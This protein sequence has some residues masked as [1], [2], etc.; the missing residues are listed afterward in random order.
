M[1]KIFIL[2][3]ML[4]YIHVFAQDSLSGFNYSRNHITITG[5]KVL[6]SWGIANIGIGAAGWASSHGG[7]NKYFYQM[8]TIW[9]VANLGVSVLGFSGAKRNLTKQ[10]NAADNL[11]AQ[12]AIEKTFLIN[13][14]LDV[15]YVG[16]G[17]Y[18]NSHGETRNND[19]LKGYGSSVIM[20]GIFLLLFDGTMYKLQRTNGNKLRQFLEKNSIS[21]TG[22]SIGIIHGL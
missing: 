15:L 7:A 14:S 16:A 17:I 6:G 4:S 5:M 18:L 10:L 22:N 9:G 3:M 8:S 13:G 19:Q 12:Q 20:Q 1:K 21:F 11:K 2:I